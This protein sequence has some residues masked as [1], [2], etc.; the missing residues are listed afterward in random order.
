MAEIEGLDLEIAMTF[1]K[2]KVFPNVKEYQVE[3]SHF[4]TSGLPSDEPLIIDLLIKCITDYNIPIQQ[5]R[6]H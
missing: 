4:E 6:L 3:L 1:F 2:K 5:V